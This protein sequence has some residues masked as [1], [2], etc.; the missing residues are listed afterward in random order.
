[1]HM[2]THG[3]Q[4]MVTEISKTTNFWARSFYNMFLYL[5]AISFIGITFLMASFSARVKKPPI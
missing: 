1:M 3:C 4:M 5:I 2:C